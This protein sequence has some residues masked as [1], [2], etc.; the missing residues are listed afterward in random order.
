MS[1]LDEETRPHNPIFQGGSAQFSAWRL[2]GFKPLQCVAVRTSFVGR[3]FVFLRTV[4]AQQ[5]WL[6]LG[7]LALV[8]A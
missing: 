6:R 8:V 7:R 4:C 3:T 5:N 2:R 1:V